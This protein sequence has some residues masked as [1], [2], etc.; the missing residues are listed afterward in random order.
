M[1]M[2]SWSFK[3]MVL[4]SRVNELKFLCLL[5]FSSKDALRHAFIDIT[6][7]EL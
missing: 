4:L 1:L 7:R 2:L 5:G 6:V 3:L